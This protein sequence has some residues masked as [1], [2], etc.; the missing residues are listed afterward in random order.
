V[1]TAGHAGLAVSKIGP[2]S[3]DSPEIFRTGSTTGQCV[4]T[5]YLLHIGRDP[6]WRNAPVNGPRPQLNSA[7]PLSLNLSY[8]LT[9]Y[10]DKDFQTE[11]LA[12]SIALQ[13]IHS[14]P[15][16]SATTAPF[17]PGDNTWSD[18]PNGEFA[19]SIEADTIEE[20]SRLWQAFAAPI[21]LSALIKAS[22]VFVT[23]VVPTSPPTPPPSTSN[24]TVA[25]FAIKPTP[26]AMAP[27]LTPGYGQQNPPVLPGTTLAQLTP[28]I[29]PLVAVG[30]VPAPLPGTPT[31]LFGSYVV[32]AGNALDLADAASV[33]LSAPG[34]AALWEVTGWRQ[35]ITSDELILALP[36]VYAAPAGS[37]LTA[38]PP[39]GIYNLGVGSGGMINSNLITIAIAPRVDGVTNPPQLKADPA[40]N[41]FTVHGA[42][43][44]PSSGV[45]LALGAAVLTRSVPA[46]PGCFTVDPTTITFVAPT[47]LARG[48]YPLL[49]TVNG[50]AASIGWL[51]IVT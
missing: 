7:Q 3:C 40:S 19:I 13:A 49:L 11:Q 42:G 30:G 1:Q 8:L 35:G 51:A 18:L 15:I 28:A 32:I 5:L 14:N 24:I 39:P 26:P 21:R 36:D 31:P 47:D 2:T 34:S 9:A 45:T 38:T 4:L 50:V 17:P 6:Y 27:T 46:T 43:F 20:M 41:I 22:V 48:T 23:P 44:I 37:P 16:M 33:Y 29:G 10:C 25:P 12:M